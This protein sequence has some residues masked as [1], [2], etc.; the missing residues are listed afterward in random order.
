MITLLLLLY[1]NL[2]RNSSA[3]KACIAHL[4][5]LCISPDVLKYSCVS[6]ADTV[7]IAT[8]FISGQRNIWISNL[9]RF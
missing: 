2:H 9:L 6:L 3:S 5:G 7:G 8:V 4:K 1:Y